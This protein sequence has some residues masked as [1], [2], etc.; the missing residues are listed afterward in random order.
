MVPGSISGVPI[1]KALVCLC[2]LGFEALKCMSY[3]FSTS[4]LIKEIR[5]ELKL[6]F[7]AEQDA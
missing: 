3:F 6:R 1:N 5:R 7:F 4:L 2:G